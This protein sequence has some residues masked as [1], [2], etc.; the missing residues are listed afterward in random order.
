MACPCLNEEEKC[1][2]GT[3]VAGGKS[4]SPDDP[5]VSM[6]PILGLQGY[7]T[8]PNILCDAGIKLG[9]SCLSSKHLAD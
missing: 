6:P 4:G 2:G 9:S 7:V 5:L 8:S 1:G 3:A